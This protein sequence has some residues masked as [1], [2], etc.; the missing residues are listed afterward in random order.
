MEGYRLASTHNGHVCS[1][2]CFEQPA[3]TSI[4]YTLVVVTRLNSPSK[5]ENKLKPRPVNVPTGCHLNICQCLQRKLFDARRTIIVSQ[6]QAELVFTVI[7]PRMK[8]AQAERREVTT[9]TPVLDPTLLTIPCL[10]R[11]FH[12]SSR[13]IASSVYC[14]DLLLWSTPE[15]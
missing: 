5:A 4:K 2:L 1:G 15:H 3:S 6:G 8:E 10:D 9:G 7:S 14:D 12:F 13:S 11:A